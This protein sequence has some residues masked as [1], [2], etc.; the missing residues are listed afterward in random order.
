MNMG[1]TMEKI[2]NSE[3]VEIKSPVPEEY[4]D[5]KDYF[6][7]EEKALKLIFT[8]YLKLLKSKIYIQAVRLR[9]SLKE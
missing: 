7:G 8:S 1:I 4:S 9:T 2:N 6:I 3:N 5:Y